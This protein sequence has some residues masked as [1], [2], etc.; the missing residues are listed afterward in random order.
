MIAEREDSPIIALCPECPSV[1][2][3][4]SGATV[5][6][7]EQLGAWA[8]PSP[9]RR[10]TG[11]SSPLTSTKF[12]SKQQKALGTADRYEERDSPQPASLQR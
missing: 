5:Q 7:N 12:T 6:I 9:S 1:P 3:G 8:Q 4:T 11:R 10:D 2:N